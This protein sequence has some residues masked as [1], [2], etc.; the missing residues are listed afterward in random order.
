MA[1]NAGLPRSCCDIK[2]ALISDGV[3]CVT[4][5][6]GI[7]DLLICCIQFFSYTQ[8][9]CTYDAPNLRY[10]NTS[11]IVDSI[12]TA[13]TGVATPKFFTVDFKN[14]T[15]EY[16]FEK[17][18][19][20]DT[21]TLTNNETVNFQIDVKDR[22]FYCNLEDY[23]GQEVVVLYRERGTN[24]WYIVGRDGGMV[25]TA[26][27]GGTG[28]DTFTPTSF[29]ISGTDTDTTQREVFATDTAT[30]ET[31]ITTVTAA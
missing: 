6:G 23:I 14:K 12:A 2:T 3:S 8:V 29:V 15:A 10:S 13:V 25:V 5:K 28:T 30:T 21:G 24:L 9:D 7:S 1:A 22:N 4:S 17:T 11:G 20:P 27:N 18:Y 26:I 16:V 31:L 19:D